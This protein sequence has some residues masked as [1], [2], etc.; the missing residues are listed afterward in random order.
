MSKEFTRI[1]FKV[2]SEDRTTSSF[3]D[4]RSIPTEMPVIKE[5]QVNSIEERTDSESIKEKVKIQKENTY[6]GVEIERR[7]RDRRFALNSLSKKSLLIEEDEKRAIEARVAEEVAT[8]S[9]SARLAAMEE[10]YQEGLRKGYDEISSRVYQEGKLTLER[11]TQILDSFEAAKADI[12]RQNER[13]II[14][15]VFKIAKMLFLK[16]LSTDKEYVL[17]LVKE[18][19]NRV[20]FREGITLK[21][22]P[23][24]SEMMDPLK[25]NLH[26]TFGSIKNLN[27]EVSPQVKLGGCLIETDWNQIDATIETQL[28]HVL[29]SLRQ[30]GSS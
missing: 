19:L 4:V 22:G 28:S 18:L 12:F 6:Q 17:R 27:I 5:F 7:Q 23:A 13:M 26:E 29:Q 3:T 30:E 21:L 11:L 8:I 1:Q 10:G 24:D 2:L 16:E 25:K 20:E 9:E 14:D 15:L